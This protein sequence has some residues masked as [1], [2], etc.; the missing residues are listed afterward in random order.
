[1]SVGN[2]TLYWASAIPSDTAQYTLVFLDYATGGYIGQSA[3]FNLTLP[4]G[5]T[6]NTNV[7]NAPAS[8]GTSST[9]EPASGSLSTGA[10]AAAIAVPIAAV[11]TILLAF[12]FL[13]RK[14]WFRKTESEKNKVINAEMDGKGIAGNSTKQESAELGA[15]AHMNWELPTTPPRKAIDPQELPAEVPLAEMNAAEQETLEPR[16]FSRISENAT[17][18]VGSFSG[19]RTESAVSPLVSQDRATRDSFQQSIRGSMQSPMSPGGARSIAPTTTGRSRFEDALYD[20]V[21]DELRR[22]DA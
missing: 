20:L 9:S 15:K 3:I 7:G 4:P 17:T 19:D 22:P 11:L 16:Q 2:Y 13:W 21:S 12:F 5:E 8:P 18:A 14:R 10:L 1:M 6:R